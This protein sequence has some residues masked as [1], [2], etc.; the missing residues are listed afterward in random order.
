MQNVKKAN[1]SEKITRKISRLRQRKEESNT[2]IKTNDQLRRSI[3][4]KKK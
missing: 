3:K 1:L 4:Q 2:F